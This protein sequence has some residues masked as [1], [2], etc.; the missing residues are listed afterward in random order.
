MTAEKRWR[1]RARQAAAGFTLIE[2][3]IVVVIIGLLASI[4]IPAFGRAVRRTKTSEAVI[5][6]RRIYDGAVT[7][8]Q[9]LDV[10]RNGIAMNSQFPES[11]PPTPGLNAC[12]EGEGEGRCVPNAQSFRTQSWNE[13]GFAISD[14]HY[15]W[16]EF[17]SEGEG[18]SAQFTARA[19]G[20]LDCDEVFSTFERP[21]F[22]DML[23]G[24]IRGGAGVFKN[25]PLE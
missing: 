3:M 8:F 16:Y 6:L 5:N 12:C 20:N 25:K 19:S 17:A 23:S 15:Y 4:A 22:V 9:A 24:R 2:L 7:S 13:L 21:G 1:T 10:E 18:V 14:P 11:A